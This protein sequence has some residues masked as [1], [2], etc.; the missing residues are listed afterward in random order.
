MPYRACIGSQGLIGLVP[1]PGWAVACREQ[2]LIASWKSLLSSYS[3]GGNLRR[4]M[5]LQHRYRAFAE[6]RN[7]LLIHCPDSDPAFAWRSIAMSSRRLLRGSE[8][9][10]TVETNFTIGIRGFDAPGPLDSRKAKSLPG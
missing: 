9:T 10:T 5:L 2:V 6:R 3:E 1:G 7:G 8:L 4:S